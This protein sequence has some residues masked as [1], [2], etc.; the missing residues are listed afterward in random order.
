MK[1]TQ[2]LSKIA[3]NVWRSPGNIRRVSNVIGRSANV[4]D[5]LP[6]IDEDR[7][8]LMYLTNF[9]FYVFNKKRHVLSIYVNDLIAFYE[10]VK[11]PMLHNFCHF[12]T[13]SVNMQHLQNV[14]D[15]VVTNWSAHYRLHN[16][17]ILEKLLLRSGTEISSLRMFSIVFRY[18]VSNN[19]PGARICMITKIKQRAIAM[20]IMAHTNLF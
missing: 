11:L 1:M 9:A 2:I 18:F 3:E 6:K 17:S 10:F 12:L 15:S 7:H 8:R 16:A 13:A 19:R 14:N 5:S 4:S 20:L